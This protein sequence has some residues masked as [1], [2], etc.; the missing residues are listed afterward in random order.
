[1]GLNRRADRVLRAFLL[2]FS[3]CG[4]VAL[5]ACSG[6]SGTV[7]EVASSSSTSTTSTTTTHINICHK[8]GILV[9]YS[10]FYLLSLHIYATLKKAQNI[11]KNRPLT[12][13]SSK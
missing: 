13:S 10:T 8:Q 5:G 2:R 6:A 9:R 4:V 12:K 3:V 11:D 1:M 7:D